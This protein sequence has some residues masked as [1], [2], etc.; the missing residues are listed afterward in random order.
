MHCHPPE[1]LHS[2]TDGLEMQLDQQLAEWKRKRLSS[3]ASPPLED[4]SEDRP[5]GAL[6]VYFQH[7]NVRVIQAPHRIEKVFH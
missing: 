5:L 7:V 4:V 1:K 6:D 3:L 2:G